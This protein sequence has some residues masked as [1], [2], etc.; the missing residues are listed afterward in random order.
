M[1]ATVSKRQH[2]TAHS[3]S[4]SCKAT[5]FSAPS[6]LFIFI[7]INAETCSTYTNT[8]P[9]DSLARWLDTPFVICPPIYIVT[10]FL[11][12]LF[13]SKIGG[14]QLNHNN[15]HN[16]FSLFILLFYCVWCVLFAHG[17]RNTIER[18]ILPGLYEMCTN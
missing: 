4:T 18:R 6:D 17:R 12:L 9:I 7:F 5:Q 1:R 16:K 15:P 14:A 13:A 2:S 3:Q 8:K 10:R 11:L